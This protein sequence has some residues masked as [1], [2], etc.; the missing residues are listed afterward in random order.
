MPPVE[1][2]RRWTL[3]MPSP[4][5]NLIRYYGALA[6]RSPLRPEVVAKVGKEAAL[7]A[8]R[9]KVDKPKKTNSWAACQARIFEVYPLVCTKCNLEMKPVAVILNDKEKTPSW[10]RGLIMMP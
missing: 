4:N 3:L 2:L 8:R 1:F 10:T 5:K 6:P 7:P 9:E